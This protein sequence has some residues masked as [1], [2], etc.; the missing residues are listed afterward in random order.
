MSQ[1]ARTFRTYLVRFA[2]I[3]GAVASLAGPTLA[4]SSAPKPATP[5]P[6]PAPAAP[7]KPAAQPA[8]TA[9][10]AEAPKA[11]P[12]ATPL[13]KDAPAAEAILDKFIEVTGGKDAYGKIK[14]RVMKGTLSIA[15]MNINGTLESYVGDNGKTFESV[16]LPGIGKMVSG[17]DGTVV[18]DNSPFMGPRILEGT[19]REM[20]LLSSQLNNTSDW[21]SMYPEVKTTAE[22]TVN[23]RPVWVV[24]QK[25]KSGQVMKCSYDK[26]TGLLIRIGMTVATPMGDIESVSD[27]SNYK[28][29]GGVKVPHT[30]T[31]EQAGSKIVSEMTDI[32]V[33]TEIPAEKFA[34]PAEIK[35]LADS[36][37]AKPADV[38]KDEP[39]KEAAPK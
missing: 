21:R 28:D 37:A 30:T 15:A 2:A 13:P 11:A 34:L 33:N 32:K 14:N 10:P 18:W 25:T 6:A 7:A 27:V 1:Y 8:D 36:K 9:K 19:E 29:V 23:D 16:D 31:V 24:E 5:T 26:E 38:K 3:A 12:A 22:A 35:A 39:K 20:K 4:Q 17:S